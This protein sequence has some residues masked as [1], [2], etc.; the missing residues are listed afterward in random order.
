MHLGSIVSVLR[1]PL[2]SGLKIDRKILIVPQECDSC[3]GGIFLSC[4]E[5]KSKVL[6]MQMLIAI[7]L[8][9]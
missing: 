9:V 2:P 8:A 5:D 6:P 3:A 7:E 4:K 1:L